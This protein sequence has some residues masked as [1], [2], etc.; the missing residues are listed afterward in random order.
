MRKLSF[1]FA[2]F[3]IIATSAC[4]T[5][6][7]PVEPTSSPTKTSLPTAKPTELPTPTQMPTVTSPPDISSAVTYPLIISSHDPFNQVVAVD[8]A[9]TQRIAYCAPSEIRI[10]QDAGETWETISTAG[11]AA[12]AGELGYDLFYGEPGSEDACAF[13][14]INM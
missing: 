11:V 2:V 7:G 12:V 9:D 8:P 10:S 14:H 3:C 1:A 4:A 5:Q 6:S 13:G